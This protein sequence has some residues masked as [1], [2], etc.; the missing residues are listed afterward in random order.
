MR[1]IPW[2]HLYVAIATAT[3]TYFVCVCMWPE[4]KPRHT[5]RIES[6][7]QGK[8]YAIEISPD[9]SRLVYWNGHR[10]GHGEA[11]LC[12]TADGSI[13]AT[14][15]FQG[16]AFSP[17]GN[18]VALFQGDSLKVYDSQSGKELAQ[19]TVEGNVRYACFGP[20]GEIHALINTRN[21]RLAFQD[22]NSGLPA[23]EI[24]ANDRA[25]LQATSRWAI[26]RQRDKNVLWDIV[27]SEP[28]GSADVHSRGTI[29]DFKRRKHHAD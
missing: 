21:G 6:P 8:A 7:W 12:R 27:T 19:H 14:G 16:W 11:L 24:K 29:E 18:L 26:I 20:D 13:L 28:L 17:K 10:D 25:F 9:A 1:T 2:L 15:W 4:P 22:L 3:A 23:N 5:F